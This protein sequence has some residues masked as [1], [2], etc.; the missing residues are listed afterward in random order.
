MTEELKQAAEARKILEIRCGSHLYGTNTPESDEDFVGVFM[1]PMEY[2]L[3]FKNVKEVTDNLV[4]KN[5]CGRNTKE[6]ID[7]KFYEFRH[8]CNLAMNNNPT[9][10]EILYANEENILYTNDLGQRL[11]E[12]RDLFPSQL[13]SKGYLGYASQQKHKMIIRSDKFNELEEGLEALSTMDGKEVMADALSQFPKIFENRRGDKKLIWCGDL[14]IERGIFVN[15]A[16]RM[17]EKRIGSATSRKELIRKHG[18]DTKFAS[19]LI[20]LLT[21]GLEFLNTGKLTFPLEN[22]DFLLEIKNGKYETQQ[23]IEIANK[24]EALYDSAK[25]KRMLPPVPKT[26][27]IELFVV[28]AMYQDLTGNQLF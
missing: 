22:K 10:L 13:M 26:K 19:H 12:N 21:E 27:K 14:Q 23:V 9:I 16:I 11:I 4:S 5:E 1:P 18:Y 15:K 8:F 17:I 28:N 6:A 24:Y 20:R 25:A 2:V 7:K 3:G